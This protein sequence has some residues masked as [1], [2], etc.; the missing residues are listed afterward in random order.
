MDISKNNDPVSR[1]KT[2]TLD[3]GI[4]PSCNK[5]IF[6]EKHHELLVVIMRHIS[7]E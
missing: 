3:K 1:T 4:I 5:A 7:A 6:A 2:W